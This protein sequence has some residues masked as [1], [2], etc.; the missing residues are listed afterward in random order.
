[1]DRLNPAAI[2]QFEHLW[3][4]YNQQLLDGGMSIGAALAFMISGA[5]TSIGAIA[6]ALTIARW[7]VVA[8]VV[9]ILW[10]GAVVCGFAYDLLA[11]A[12]LF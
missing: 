1:M 9:G 2:H 7:R 12:S 3:E 5:G 6:G 8:L 4:R 10:I 11:T